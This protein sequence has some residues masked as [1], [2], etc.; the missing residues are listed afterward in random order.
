[1]T[2]PWHTPPLTLWQ[3]G[4]TPPVVNQKWM[5]SALFNPWLRLITGLNKSGSC[6]QQTNSNMRSADYLHPTRHLH[7]FLWCCCRTNSKKVKEAADAMIWMQAA[8]WEFFTEKQ[9]SWDARKGQSLRGWFRGARD[10]TLLSRL[11]L[12]PS[13]RHTFTVNYTTIS[14]AKWVARTRLL[15][16]CTL[17]KQL[18]ASTYHVMVCGCI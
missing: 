1:M 8:G 3:L 6:Y 7:V 2:C 15:E 5:W 17:Y 13:Y 18:S 14:S 16:N 11:L 9:A 10:V 12:S 4:K